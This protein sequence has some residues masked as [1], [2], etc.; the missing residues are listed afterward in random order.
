M[1]V[2]SIRKGPRGTSMSRPMVAG[3]QYRCSECGR[4]RMAIRLTGVPLVCPDHP[5]ADLLEMTTAQQAAGCAITAELNAGRSLDDIRVRD[6]EPA[7]DGPRLR[8]ALTMLPLLER[9]DGLP[10]KRTHYRPTPGQHAPG[11]G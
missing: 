10:E 1:K 4:L 7:G 6:I 2:T 11:I 5:A 3:Y 9:W 8:A